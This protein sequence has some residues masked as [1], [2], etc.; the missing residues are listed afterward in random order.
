MASILGS[1]TNSTPINVKRSAPAP[2]S[3][4][5]TANGGGSPDFMCNGAGVQLNA[6]TAEP[7]TQFGIWTSS[8]PGN[9]ILN[10]NGGTAYF[11]S[12][13]NNCYGIDIT[14]SNCFGSVQ[15]GITICVDNCLTGKPVYKV[16]PNPASDIVNITFDKE[17]DMSQLPQFIKLFSEIGAKEVK[18]V[19]AEERYSSADFQ[20]SRTIPIP[21][22]DLLRGVYY[23]KM[24]DR[25]G[26]AET[27]RIVVE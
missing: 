6:Y 25:A 10:S 15:K 1:I 4:L 27:V 17:S 19:E 12:Y 21:V 20:T 14:V 16:Y 3:L 5:V 9:T 11:N 23:L 7:G 26:N 22:N 18:N 2:A 13:V 8:D 24:M